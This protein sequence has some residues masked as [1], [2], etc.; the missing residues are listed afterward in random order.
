MRYFA[1]KDGTGKITTVESYSRDLDVEGAVEITEGEF[2]DF[3][4]S[5]PVVEPEP[6]LADQVA[7]LNARVERLEMR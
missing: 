7:D 4:A 6:D 1:R 2:K 5:L 3:V